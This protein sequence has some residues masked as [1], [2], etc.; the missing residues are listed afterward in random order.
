M[1]SSA[2]SECTWT[3]Y[4]NTNAPGG[5]PRR[6]LDLASC[7]QACITTAYCIGIDIDRNPGANLCWL[8]VVPQATGALSPFTNVEH[9]TLKRNYGCPLYGVFLVVDCFLRYISSVN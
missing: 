9:Y 4:W 2:D 3:V 5:Y 1:L 8:T 6:D 7:Q